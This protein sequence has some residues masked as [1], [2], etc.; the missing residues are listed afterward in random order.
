MN[1]IAETELVFFTLSPIHGTGGFAKRDLAAG[2]KVIEYVGKRIDKAES[3]R[4]CQ[5]NNEFIFTLNETEDIDGSVP[6]NPARFLN[7]SC[8]PNCEAEVADDHIWIRAIRVIRA[9]EE[10]TFNYGYD[11]VDYRE[12]PCRCGSPECVGYMIAE[13]FFPHVRQ[14]RELSR[15]TGAEKEPGVRPIAR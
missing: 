12:Y 5:E 1:C 14:Q 13:E 9:G 8:S 2:E 11:L 6:W 3:L 7:H 15:E 4:G 10:I